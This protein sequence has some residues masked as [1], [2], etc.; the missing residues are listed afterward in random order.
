[1]SAASRLSQTI[2]KLSTSELSGEINLKPEAW[3][4]LSQVD[5]VRTLA[6]IAQRTGMDAATA[7]AIAD[8]LLQAHILEIASERATPAQLTV[9][10]AF[11]DGIALELARAMGPMARLIVEDAIAALGETQEKFP[12]ERLADLVERVSE[13]IRDPKKRIHFQQVMLEA[14]RK[15]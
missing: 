2:F 10:S 13:E 7:S 11:F 4:V 14:I 9:N 12:R 8:T 6:E 5:G 15:I 3:R 1:M